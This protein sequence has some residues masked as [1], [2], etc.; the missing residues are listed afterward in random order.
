MTP[1]SWHSYPSIYA[2]GHR[3]VADL[4]TVPVIVQEKIDGSQFSFCMSESGEVL[5]KSKGASLVVGGP[6]GMFT[7]AIN[8]VL[9]LGD[10]L[11]RDWTYRGEVLDK[12]KHN[13]LAYDRVPDGNV[14]LFD[15]NDG[16]E[17]FLPHHEM[18][19]EAQRLG[20]ESVPHLAER[21]P[22]HP[23]TEET[24]RD[25]LEIES[26]LGGQKIEGI[27][28]K[29][30]HY[31]LYGIDKHV[32]MGKFV[33]EKFKEV[34]AGEWKTNNPEQNDIITTLANVYRTP[35]RWQK[36]AQHLA[37]S[38]Q[39]ENSPRD[40]GP[41]MKEC[42]L[43]TLKEN[44]EE[45]KDALFKWAWPNISRQITR[46]LPEWWKDELLTKQFEGEANVS[47]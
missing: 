45:I 13:V 40:I 2:L 28:I 25:L 1:D 17:S 41:L 3:A 12:P 33:S 39:L 37:E 29:P 8:T 46:G 19:E 43:D 35:A 7:R 16:Q 22:D 27:V 23:L 4:F 30:T 36:A 20:L 18:Y 14:I 38:G 5:V 9:S 44:E 21:D 34:H 47:L 32:L 6:T 26:C 10:K 42:N 11:H 24:I 31:N 15:I